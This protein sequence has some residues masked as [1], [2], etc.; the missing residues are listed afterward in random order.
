[1]MRLTQFLLGRKGLNTVEV[2]VILA[3]VLGIALLF[4]NEIVSFVSDLIA[5]IF[6]TGKEFDPTSI[7]STP[8]STP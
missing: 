5:T 4:R 2:V 1:M 8:T 6:G 7:A 3:V